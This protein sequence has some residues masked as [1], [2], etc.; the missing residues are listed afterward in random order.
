MLEILVSDN[1]QTCVEMNHDTNTSICGSYLPP[2]VHPLFSYGLG[3]APGLNQNL[4]R[5]ETLLFVSHWSI[6]AM[7]LA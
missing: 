2:R 3:P 6:E 7:R 1:M 5:M 4:P